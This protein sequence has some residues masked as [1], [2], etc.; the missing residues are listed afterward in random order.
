MDVIDASKVEKTTKECI[1]RLDCLFRAYKKDSEFNYQLSVSDSPWNTLKKRITSLE[2]YMESQKS[3]AKCE[4]ECKY[5]TLR[6]YINKNSSGAFV[7]FTFNLCSDTFSCISTKDF[8]KKYGTTREWILDDYRVIE[9]TSTISSVDQGTTH[10]LILE[11]LD[12]N[13]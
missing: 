2:E 1:E 6:E 13:N 9:T 7:T 4:Y 8:I 3:K 12:F 10:Y 11:P 5:I